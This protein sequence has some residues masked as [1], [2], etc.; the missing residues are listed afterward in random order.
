MAYL[1]AK[2]EEKVLLLESGW[3]PLSSPCCPS[4]SFPDILLRQRQEEAESLDANRDQVQL[5]QSWCS[6]GFYLIVVN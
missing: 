1:V 5:P 3:L 6:D 2:S 4:C